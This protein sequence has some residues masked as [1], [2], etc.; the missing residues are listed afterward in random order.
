MNHMLG[1]RSFVTHIG[2]ICPEY[3]IGVWRLL[4][5]ENYPGAL[6]E[7]VRVEWQ[8]DDWESKVMQETGG[9][10][11]YLKAAMEAVGLAAGP[12]RPPSV[13]PSAALLAELRE[14]L[15]CWGILPSR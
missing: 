5:Q 15:D 1:G 10:G 12:P 2:N 4:Q 3:V 14:L 9:H 8:W 13:R 7:L 11:S 6:A